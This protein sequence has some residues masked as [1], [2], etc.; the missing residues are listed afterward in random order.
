[1]RNAYGTLPQPDEHHRTHDYK[2][3]AKCDSRPPPP[4]TAPLGEPHAAT[5]LR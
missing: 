4:G 2:E 5:R 3:Y 1:M